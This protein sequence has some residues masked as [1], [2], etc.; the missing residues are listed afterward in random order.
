MD[1]V[2][3]DIIYFMEEFLDSVKLKF[4]LGVKI[5]VRDILVLFNMVFVRLIIMRLLLD[6]V[7]LDFKNYFLSVEG[8]FFV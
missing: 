6:L 8:M 4:V 2:F 1:K 5:I 7:G 3:D